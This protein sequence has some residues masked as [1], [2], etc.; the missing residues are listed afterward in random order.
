MP[1][2]LLIHGGLTGRDLSSARLKRYAEALREAAAAGYG[3]LANGARAAALKAVALLEDN[4]LFN[5]GTGSKLQADGHARMSAACMDS[6]SG[7][8]SGVINV[9]YLR[10]PVLLADRLAGEANHVLAGSGGVAYARTQGFASYDPVT[11]Q[12]REEFRTGPGGRSG[13][14]GAVALDRGGRLCAATST[15]GIG[16]ELPGR[17]SDSATVAGTYCSAAAA[18]SVTGTGEHIVNAAAAAR[19]VVR[20]E[21]GMALSEAV[22][23]TLSEAAQRGLELGLI[24]LDAAGRPVSGESAGMMTLY[25]GIREDACWD[26]LGDWEN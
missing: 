26:F 22:E 10:H 21:D 14:V 16:G 3:A 23:K 19:I 1:E 15:G 17:V 13:T 20:C 12:R 8:F 2:L 24:A 7:V 9:E 18:V 4:P 6:E 11:A 25:C 5:A